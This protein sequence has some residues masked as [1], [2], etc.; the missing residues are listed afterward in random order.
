MAPAVTAGLRRR[1]D[2]VQLPGVFGGCGGAGDVLPHRRHHDDCR[3]RRGWR[4]SRGG[5]LHLLQ[6][7]RPSQ[8]LRRGE[9]R[10]Q[11]AIGVQSHREHQGQSADRAG[12]GE[13]RFGDAVPICRTV[14]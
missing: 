1:D 7:L 3:R 11:R 5:E 8:P 14:G 10:T 4:C 2:A 13:A 12:T 9:D 6:G